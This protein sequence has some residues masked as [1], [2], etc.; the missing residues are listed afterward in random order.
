MKIRNTRAIV[1]AAGKSSRFK[2]D[3]SKLLYSIC[4]QPMILYPIK[5]LKEMDIPITVVV[6]YQAEDIK[7]VINKAGITVDYVTQKSALGTGDAVSATRKTWDRENI[8]VLNGDGPLLTKEIISELEEKHTKSDSA[9]SFLSAHALNPLGYGRIIKNKSCISIIEDRNLT[10]EQRF[11]TLIN[12][13]IYLIKRDFLEKNIDNIKLDSEKGEYYITDLAQIA[14]SQNL[15]VKTVP[16]PYDNVRGVN[17]LEELW[18]VEQIKR[19][20]LI[21]SWM[22]KGVHFELA[23]SIHLDWDVQI[24]SGSFIGTGVHLIKGTKIGKNCVVNAFS[25]VDNSELE[26]GGY[27]HSHSVIQG[28]KI[29]KN[30]HVGPFARFRK[31][32]VVGKN[33][34]IGNFVEIKNSIIGDNTTTKHLSY[35]GDSIIGKNVN[36]GAGTI[37]CNYDG[38]EKN[39]TIIKD[40]VFIGSNNTLIAP[41][42]VED[43][44]YTAGGSTINKD[45]PKDSLGIGRCKQEN[46]IDYAKKLKSKKTKEKKE[47]EDKIKLNFV[48]A[49]KAE[50]IQN[51]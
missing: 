17:T 28:S 21:K 41:V 37:T 10:E 15:N 44:A 49:V 5:L 39:K 2:T 50:D 19:S 16:V 1:L 9:F 25:I 40:N 31:N 26:D 27:I 18:A 45:I 42:T 43:N 51:L 11:T 47:S 30:S 22:L 29:G 4:G 33:V 13:G 7:D 20:Q 34:N 24:G 12:A 8:L 32:V 3:K 38:F 36:I 35:L 23:Q 46:K 14:S 6:G 48:G